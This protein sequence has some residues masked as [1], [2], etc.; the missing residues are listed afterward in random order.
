MQ[1]LLIPI[2]GLFVGLL[3]SSFATAEEAPVKVYILSGQSNMVGIGQVDGG[4]SRWGDEFSNPVLSVYPGKPDAAVNYDD[5]EAIKTVKL[6]ALGGVRGEPYPGEGVHVVRGGVKMPETG[7]YE[8]RPGYESSTENIM[9]VNGKEVHRKEPGEKS[10]FSHIKLEA[11]E[12][13]PFKI[14]YLNDKGNTLGWL[15]RMAVPGTLK[16]LVNFDG[17]FQYLTDGEGNFVPR[18]DVYYKG[19]VTAGADKWLDIGCGADKIS[20]NHFLTGQ[21]GDMRLP[22]LAGGRAIRT[23][24][25]R[26]P[27]LRAHMR[28]SMRK[29]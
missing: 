15:A 11:G 28:S 1:K 16:A 29:T 10:K 22:V 6:E 24:A 2:L 9:V 4:G 27:V 25:N 13:V 5:L 14:T 26:E 18:D 23:V 7:V 8:F 3:A 19:V 21:D 20:T 12:A 17:K